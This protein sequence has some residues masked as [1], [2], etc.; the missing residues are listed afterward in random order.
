MLFITPDNGEPGVFV[1]ASALEGATSLRDGQEVSNEL[2][3]DRK[4]GRSK[5][6][7]KS[8]TST[9]LRDRNTDATRVTFAFW[10][11]PSS[12]PTI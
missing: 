12:S 11:E 7:R 6:S 5:A 10:C 2:G 8:F 9:A 4:T 3:Q 1:H